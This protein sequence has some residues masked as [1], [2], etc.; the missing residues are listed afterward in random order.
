MV[1]LRHLATG[2]CLGLFALGG[3]AA[4]EE[5]TKL[6]DTGPDVISG[7]VRFVN[8]AR[9]DVA[10]TAGGSGAL[11]LGT[12]MIGRFQAVPARQEL[13]ATLAVA[14]KTAEVSVTLLPDEFVTIAVLDDAASLVLRDQPQDFN[15]LKA[16]IA[17]LN[18]DPGC[19][20]GVMRA[21]AKKTVVFSAVAP[22]QLARRSVNPVA[23]LIEAGCGEAAAGGVLDL[24]LLEAG[25][26]YSVVVVPDGAGGHVLI[27]G[28]DERAR[29]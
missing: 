23:A 11:A 24:G 20:G 4:A 10:I 13:T 12:G 6:Y 27:G 29:Y 14:G 26:R 17:F 8:A 5:Q 18:A 25:K 19:A 1:K 9:A 28:Q 7:Y 22:G 2:A 15:A 16:D 3:L 21:G